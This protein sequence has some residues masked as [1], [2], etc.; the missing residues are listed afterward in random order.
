M[1]LTEREKFIHHFVTLTT[2]RVILS[3]LAQGENDVNVYNVL[4]K[5]SEDMTFIIKK[6]QETR[7]RKLDDEQVKS[8][9]DELV[10]EALL[11]GNIIN[12]SLR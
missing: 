6:I 7:C 8:L 1:T 9:I 4:D 11:G 3:K 10:E 2:V 5:N 12:D